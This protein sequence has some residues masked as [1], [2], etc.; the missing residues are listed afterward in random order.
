MR[1]TYG[2]R[3][4]VFATV[5]IYGLIG[6]QGSGGQSQSSPTGLPS[7]MPARIEPVTSSFDY[8]RRVVMI[9][10]RDGVRLHTGVLVPK[11]A[12]GA[13]VLLTRTPH[14]AAAPTQQ[15]R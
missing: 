1:R 14:D 13:P 3:S 4:A 5:I 15:T 7:E 11:G 10:M 9:P 2:G 8:V 12:K 6:V